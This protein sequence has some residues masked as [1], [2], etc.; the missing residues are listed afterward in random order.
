MESQDPVKKNGLVL[1]LFL[2]SI[3][4]FVRTTR[5]RIG[6]KVVNHDDIKRIESSSKSSR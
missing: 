2:L 6:R 4:E 1:G 5:S 3:F